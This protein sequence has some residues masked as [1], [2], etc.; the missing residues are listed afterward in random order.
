MSNAAGT[1]IPLA[2]TRGTTIH[3]HTEHQRVN[4]LQHHREQKTLSPNQKLRRDR[5]TTEGSFS[6]NQ[7]QKLN[8]IS[9]I[10]RAAP[11]TKSLSPTTS[12]RS[13][14]THSEARKQP[15]HVWCI[16]FFVHAQQKEKAF[17]EPKTERT[18]RMP[19]V[20]CRQSNGRRQG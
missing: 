4:F 10:Q 14:T 17:I 7:K 6:A 19:K 15:R 8:T 20:N 1:I 5:Q 16:I 3:S 11:R 18:T 13:H 12:A 9:S 2:P